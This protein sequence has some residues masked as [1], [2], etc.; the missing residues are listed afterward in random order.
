LEEA[1]KL[2]PEGGVIYLLT[3]GNASGDSVLQPGREISPE[4]IFKVADDGQRALKRRAKIHAIYY[5]TGAR[6]KVRS[7]RC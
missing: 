3:D 4:D 5:V 6:T 7:A 2:K 1:F